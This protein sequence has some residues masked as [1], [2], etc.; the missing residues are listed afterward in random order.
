MTT[1]SESPTSVGSLK[2]LALD[3]GASWLR[4]FVRLL[5]GAGVSV[6]ATAQTLTEVSDRLDREF[7]HVSL[8]DMSL[9]G[10]RNRDG[11]KVISKI[12]QQN[13]GAEAILAT[14]YGHPQEGHEATRHGAFDVLSKEHLDYAATVLTIQKACEQARANL[15]GYRVG[16]N[17]LAGGPTGED[18]VIE[19]S[20]IIRVIGGGVAKV[21]GLTSRLLKGLYPFLRLKADPYPKID[22]KEKV[23][24]GR[25]W[26][27]MIGSPVA[28]VLGNRSEIMRRLETYKENPSQG[29]DGNVEEILAHH[30]EGDVAGLVMRVTGLNFEQFEVQQD[31][32]F[33]SKRR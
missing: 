10:S 15:T 8:I 16:L 26:S 19:E 3:D 7:F 27:K 14:A 32:I 1:V 24:Y 25:Y 13:E 6:I 20:N 5:S 18:R 30:E 9:V 28:V 29:D 23:V 17:L 22:D 2:G 4:K 21:E 33:R 12:Y 31:P 11:L